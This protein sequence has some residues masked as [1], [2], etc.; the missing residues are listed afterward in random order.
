MYFL[1][2]SRIFGAS[3]CGDR[4][5]QDV[6]NSR[7]LIF[8]FP[9]WVVQ[10]QHVGM[11][12]LIFFHGDDYDKLVSWNV[13]PCN[14]VPKFL[15]NLL[16]SISDPEDGGSRFFWSINL[17]IYQN[18]WLHFSEADMTLQIFSL[19]QRFIRSVRS[20]TLC[21]VPAEQRPQYKYALCQQISWRR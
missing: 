15:R 5:W 17:G 1:N 6:I 19:S 21:H 14:L 20:V 3:S 11:W 9:K 8:I 18:T 7:V 2:R 16:P 10:L 4:N 12:D 13:M